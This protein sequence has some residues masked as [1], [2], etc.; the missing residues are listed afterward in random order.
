V[1][2]CC[3]LGMQPLDITS[4]N[5]QLCL[6]NLTKTDWKLNLNYWTAGTTRGCKDNWAWCS[7]ENP[8]GLADDLIWES[9]SPNSKH[10]CVHMKIK[11][12]TSEGPILIARNCSD[13][14]VFACKVR[15]IILISFNLI[16]YTMHLDREILRRHQNA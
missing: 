7:S 14:F 6:K 4:K 10:D 13:R 16:S 11:H 9:G 15:H 5:E 12:K 8:V 1:D 3:S 2:I